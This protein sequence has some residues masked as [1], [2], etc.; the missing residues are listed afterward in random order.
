MSAEERRESVVRAAITEFARGGYNGTSTEVIARRVGVSQPYLFRLF[1]NKQAIF[2]A[3]AERCL[4]DTRQVFAAASKGLEGEEALHAM[5]A[6]YQQLIVDDGEKLM[7]QMQMYA[8]V[9]AAEA[10]GD[11]AFGESLRA[12]WVRMWDD[13]HITL[14]AD[15][16]ETTT[17]LAY[18]MLV[19]TLASLG[20]PGDHRVWSGFYVS[21]R[22]TE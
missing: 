22:P 2:L 16:S 1:P 20:F 21:G 18:G 14:G 4:E 12:A 5:A 11:H 3:A 9:A 10:A 19:N 15:E 6:A 7:M 8:A 17:F 13:V